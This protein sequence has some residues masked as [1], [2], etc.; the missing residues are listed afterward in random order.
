M[1]N[2]VIIGDVHMNRC[3]DNIGVVD[4]IIDGD[5]RGE[6]HVLLSLN[7]RLTAA[8]CAL[9]LAPGSVAALAAA[10]LAA[11]AAAAAA[12]V[13]YA[14][15]HATSLAGVVSAAPDAFVHAAV[16]A[17]RTATVV[18]VADVAVVTVAEFT[19]VADVSFGNFIG[20]FGMNDR[21]D[22]RFLFI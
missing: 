14:L 1:R 3:V 5:V 17:D 9:A 13:S 8:L 15:V 16:A 18:S 2:V 10:A 7:F 21:V 12:G 4:D 11:V 22:G 19:S 6:G 20:H